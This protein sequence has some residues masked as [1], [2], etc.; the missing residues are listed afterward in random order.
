MA[1]LDERVL[2]SRMEAA[3]RQTS[4][5]LSR[6]ERRIERRAERLTVTLRAKRRSFSRRGPKWRP[7]GDRLL[8]DQVER[9]T[10]ER[11]G[12]IDALSRK[13]ARQERAIAVFRDRRCP[14]GSRAA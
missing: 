14:E 13:L 5:H 1:G 3:C 10:F 4:N 6:I 11:R 12:E 9:L 2:L 7:E 8:R